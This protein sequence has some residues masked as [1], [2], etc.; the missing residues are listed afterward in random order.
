MRRLYTVLLLALLVIVFPHFIFA[1]VFPTLEQDPEWIIPVVGL[2]TVTEERFKLSGQ[3]LS[4]QG[5]EWPIVQRITVE[6]FSGFLDTSVYNLGAYLLDDDRVYFNDFSSGLTGLLYDFCAE[7]GDTL[8]IVASS[9]VPLASIAVV[10][11]NVIGADDENRPRVISLRVLEGPG[12]GVELRWKEGLGDIK[13]PFISTRCLDL[14]CDGDYVRNEL[15]LHGDTIVT[16]GN[17]SII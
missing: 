17:G 7:E 1:Q 16:N 15:I 4:L 13:Y 12:T 8:D 5:K 10:V 11:T 2:G 9:E 6:D 3:T 14:N